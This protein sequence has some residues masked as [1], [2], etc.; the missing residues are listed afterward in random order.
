MIRSSATDPFFP[1]ACHMSQLKTSRIKATISPRTLSSSWTSVR[2]N[3]SSPGYSL[4]TQIG[5]MYHHPDYFDEPEIFKP[6]RYLNNQHGTK[7][8]VNTTGFR[9]NL[10]F[11]AGRVG[12]I[13]SILVGVCQI[14]ILKWFWIYFSVFVP[15]KGWQWGLLYSV[16]LSAYISTNT[17]SHADAQYNEPSLGI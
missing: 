5:G 16:H 12:L 3:R 6:E 15:V 13:A 2:C 7:E 10:P 14:P 17:C 11:G 9:D 1:L 4:M 8:G